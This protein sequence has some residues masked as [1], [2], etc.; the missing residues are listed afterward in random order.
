MRRDS[1]FAFTIDA[2]LTLGATLL[3]MLLA[4]WLSVSN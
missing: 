2:A 1:T 4:G 3:L